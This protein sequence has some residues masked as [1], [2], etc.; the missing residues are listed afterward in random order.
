LLTLSTPKAGEFVEWILLYL[1][2]EDEPLL[3]ILRLYQ[4]EEGIAVHTTNIV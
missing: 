1:I 3:G 4:R 2:F